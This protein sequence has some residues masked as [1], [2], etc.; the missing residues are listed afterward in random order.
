VQ[1]A[2]VD[3]AE[4]IW[5]LWQRGAVIYVC[6]DAQHMLSGVRQALEKI[7]IDC[8]AI[9]NKSV[10]ETQA[11]DWLRDMEVQGRFLIDAWA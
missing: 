8:Q 4:K 2:L 7:Y 6:G 3:H 9:E 11:Q 5:A 10:T 1:D